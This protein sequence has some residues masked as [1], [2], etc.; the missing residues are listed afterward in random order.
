MDKILACIDGSR[1]TA[2]VCDHAVWVSRQTHAPLVF[3]HAIRHPH[4]DMPADYSGNIGL[5][6][7]EAL[8]ERIVED[9][10][11]RAKLLREQGRALLDDAIAHATS[12]GVEPAGSLLRN[13]RVVTA[14]T[15]Q[16][17]DT[18][19]IIVGKQGHD[20]DMVERHV[21]SHLESLIRTI[22]RPVLVA[23]PGFTQPE[24]FLI[25]YDGSDAAEQTL[26]LV[27]EHPLL[28]GLEAHVLLVGSDDQGSRDKLAAAARRLSHDGRPVVT[29]LKSGN[30]SDAVCDYREANGIGLLAMGAYGH[31]R[32]RSW[33]IGST[34]TDMIMRSPIPLLIMR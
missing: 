20:G 16:Q 34:T 3:L 22:A 29:A 13:D 31:S 10:E 27:A 21:G 24:R 6:G 15:E 8:L 5:G 23:P 2:S 4:A 1:S 26:A 9:E 11:K 12:Q 33:F 28:A 14:I 7:R 18:A 32:L 30:V 25:A 19:L 17:T